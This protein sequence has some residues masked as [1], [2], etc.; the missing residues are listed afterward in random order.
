ML[1]LLRVSVICSGAGVGAGVG[2]GV[3]VGAGVGVGTGVGVGV[4][5]GAG[6]GVGSTVLPLA[7]NFALVAGPTIPSGANPLAD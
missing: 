7:F 6:V 2:V 4:G 5:V 3:G 1:P